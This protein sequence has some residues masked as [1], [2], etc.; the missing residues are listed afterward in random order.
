M[1]FILYRKMVLSEIQKYEIVSRY[2]NS[3]WSMQKIADSMKIS[4]ITVSLWLSRYKKSG[5]IERKRGTGIRKEKI[6][7]N[8]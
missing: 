4:R 1:Y 2:N 8:Q 6:A 3:D 7:N 5:T